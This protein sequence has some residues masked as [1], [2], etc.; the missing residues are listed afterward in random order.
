MAST[1][2]PISSSKPLNEEER[3]GRAKSIEKERLKENHLPSGDASALG[4]SGDV[5]RDEKGV[6]RAQLNPLRDVVIVDEVASDEK[7]RGLGGTFDRGIVR[8]RRGLIKGKR[9]LP[10]RQA[11]RQLNSM[12]ALQRADERLKSV[13]DG[14]GYIDFTSYN[15]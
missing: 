8:I 9:P 1:K 3:A 14:R 7:V 5:R 13:R 2:K 10:K 11:A 12:E 6:K 15:D 4:E